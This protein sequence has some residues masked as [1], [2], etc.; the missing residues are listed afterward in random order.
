MKEV[1]INY[2][3]HLILT[4]SQNKME[5]EANTAFSQRFKLQPNKYDFEFLFDKTT[6]KE[7]N[8]LH[9]ISLV[10]KWRNYIQRNF[11]WRQNLATTF[12]KLIFVTIDTTIFPFVVF[13]ALYALCFTHEQ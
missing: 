7:T 1:E 10:S 5:A 12:S 9:K 4:G 8:L 6:V 13:L 11:K 2:E 3:I